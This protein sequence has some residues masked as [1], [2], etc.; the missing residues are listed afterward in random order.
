[1]SDVPTEII[2]DDS[3][4]ESDEE[5]VVQA[6]E[7]GKDDSVTESD[8]EFVVPEKGKGKATYAQVSKVAES[9]EEDEEVEEY[10]EVPAKR[11]RGAAKG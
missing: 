3:K 8:E 10:I 1:M 5:F 6:K 4:T 2:E 7:K 11:K 9:D